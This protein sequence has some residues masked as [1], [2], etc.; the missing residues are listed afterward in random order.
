[1]AKKGGG[2]SL[3]ADITN[4]DE[5]DTLMERKGLIV[6]DIYTDWC[7]P[8]V[9][10]MSNLKKVKLEIGSE[11]LH[12]AM[13]NADH[14]SKL[15]RFK[16]RSEPTWMF[17]G[18]GYLLKVSYGCDAPN[19]IK[20]I[21]EQLKIETEVLEGKRDRIFYPF[22]QMT[23]DEKRKLDE[24]EGKKAI[25]QAKERA[26]V[27]ARRDK[28]KRRY[29]GRIA[30]KFFNFSLVIY[31]PNAIKI[32][33]EEGRK[34]APAAYKLMGLYDTVGLSIV[35]QLEVQ[36]K[37]EE[38]VDIFYN[39]NYNIPQK[40]VELMLKEEVI[41]SLVQ[42]TP[43]L[44][45]PKP[46][47]LPLKTDSQTSVKSIT[48][49]ILNVVEDNLC[50]LVYGPTKNP[51]TAT[52]NSVYTTFETVDAD[53]NKLPPCWTPLEYI[54]KCAAAHVIFPAIIAGLNVKE[55]P[56]PPPCYIMAFDGERAQEILDA[57]KQFA[58]EIVHLG[59]FDS[60][61]AEIAK[62]LCD[63]VYELEELPDE[64]YDTSKIVI[65]VSREKSDPTLVMTQLGPTYVSPD[66]KNAE[67]EVETFF[68]PSIYEE[69][70]ID[71]WGPPP[72]LTPLQW[73][74]EEGNE[75]IED[76]MSDPYYP[77]VI[78]RA[79]KMVRRF[80]GT[81][82]EDGVQIP[83]P[84]EEVAEIEERE[85]IEYEEM[86]I[87]RRKERERRKREALQRAKA[88]EAGYEEEEVAEEEV[89][90]S[91]KEEEV[92]GREDEGIPI[93][94]EE[95]NRFLELEKEI[96]EIAYQKQREEEEA[97]ERERLE[98][99]RPEVKKKEEVIKFTEA[100]YEAF[101]YDL[102]RKYEFLDFM[103]VMPGLIKKD[104]PP[105]TTATPQ[106]Q[107]APP[108]QRPK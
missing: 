50:Q 100:Q 85:R 66:K 77:D 96:L 16:G 25:E 74:D 41:V 2:G 63:T 1:M 82:I 9:G 29:L 18:T 30:R 22:D 21:I 11:Y 81:E 72:H 4:D 44:K 27:E 86:R 36:L 20:E 54:S 7:G 97:R 55:I 52:P 8:C 15:D 57:I 39:S 69:T 92:E 64:I 95:Y 94:E 90:E 105:P 75:Y 35:D 103:D 61:V 68:P 106:Q 89:V 12:L 6:I 101:E 78:R 33:E 73:F 43:P 34:T 83:I 42:M 58:S 45:L 59:Y 91:V 23:P 51:E 49:D 46:E 48:A 47:Q 99:K 102:F 5:W 93:K 70:E 19:L 13:A 26:E 79:R 38:I 24:I 71:P 67:Q 53:G 84:P 17:V 104:Q 98:K 65:A 37:R 10:M 76:Y 32:S 28:V 108:P 56:V 31:F 40:L 14:I 88:E 80:D 60:T 87:R 3:Q 107:Q 62:K